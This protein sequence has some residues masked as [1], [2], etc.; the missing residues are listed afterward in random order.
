MAETLNLKAILTIIDNYIFI[1]TLEYT[2]L[3]LPRWN[4]MQFSTCFI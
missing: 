3:R 1:A 2:Q 4:E